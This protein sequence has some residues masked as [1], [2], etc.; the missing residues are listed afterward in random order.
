MKAVATVAMLVLVIGGG[1]LMA[2]DGYD[3]RPVPDQVFQDWI[4]KNLPPVSIIRDCLLDPCIFRF[5]PLRRHNSL[6]RCKIRPHHGAGIQ[7]D[8]QPATQRHAKP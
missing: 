6:G 2:E 7:K 1:G 3:R 5:H 4:A 8:Q